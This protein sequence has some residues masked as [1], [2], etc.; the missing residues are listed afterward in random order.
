LGA[1]GDV[2]GAGGKLGAGVGSSAG[3]GGSVGT[4]GG[5]GSTGAAGIVGIGGSAG[6][7]GGAV[8]CASTS[9]PQS[10]PSTLVPGQWTLLSARSSQDVHS[11]RCSPSTL[12]SIPTDGSGLQKS[13]DVGSTWATIGDLPTPLSLGVM[14][15]D[16]SDGLRMYYGGGVGRASMGFWISKDGGG[17]WKQPKGF[18][19]GANN[20][21]GGWTNDV[22]Q[23]VADPNDFDHVLVTFHSGFE[24]KGDAGVLESKDGGTSW[25]RHAP[26]A[27]WGAGQGI[28]FLG[29]ATTWLF[30]TQVNGYWRTTDAGASWTQVTTHN[31]MHGACIATYSK[32]GALYVG[33]NNQ[34]MRSTDNG[35]SFS[36]VGPST[37]DGYYQIIGDGSF[38]YAQMAQP[39]H[40]TVGPQPYFTSPDG[41]GLT[42]TAYNSQTFSNGPYRLDFDSVNRIIYSANWDAGLWALRVK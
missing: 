7:S 27:G 33:S 24:F 26:R 16:P 38:L 2:I 4:G 12:Y 10:A 32:A 5:G 34:I 23:V 30:A 31:S 19:D 14:A 39:G 22:Y 17:T 15:I 6:A 41:D 37:Q 8:T 35:S 1:G 25:T 40:N 42:W 29:N 13:T 20:S 9:A 28:S 36:L 3:S 11:V 18:T 21:V